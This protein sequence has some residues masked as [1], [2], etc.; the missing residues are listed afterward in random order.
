MPLASER[1]ALT[2]IR[3]G[4]PTSSTA[5][6][7]NPKACGSLSRPSPA[8]SSICSPR[9][10]SCSPSS[11]PTRPPASAAS[12]H[13]QRSRI[14]WIETP[15]ATVDPT[16]PY[17]VMLNNGRSITVFFYDGP[18]SR[19]IAFE[20]LLNDGETFARR[21]IS[22]FNPDKPAS[23]PQ[24]VHVATD[25]E[26]YGHHHKHGE[27]ALSY[28]L[29]YIKDNNLARLT[30]YGEYL[31]K[32]PPTGRPKSSTTPPGPAP[33]ASSAGVPTAA[34][35]AAPTGTSVGALPFARLSISFATAPHP[36]PKPSP[37]HCSKISGLLATPTFTSS[38]IAPPI[39]STASSQ[40]TPRTPSPQ[41]NASPSSNSS[42]S[43]ATPSSCTP[44]AAGSSTTSPASRPSRSSPTPDA[45]S[46]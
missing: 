1:D 45:S 35:V 39:T 16:Q 17:L 28:A 9:K 2:Q 7:A 30:N 29:N 31:E 22:N 4:I 20:G 18:P 19:A 8:P 5:S 41:P 36:S 37:S 42:S 33:T 12:L 44:P 32:F 46:S 23:D 10:P 43:N 3:W 24:L 11:L 40:P 14:R 38:S 21:L 27:M 15:D 6:A 13:R 34:A 26:S 25:G